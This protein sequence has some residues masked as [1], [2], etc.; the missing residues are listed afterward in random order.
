MG[1]VVN[2]R[3][4]GAVIFAGFDSTPADLLMFAVPEDS[5]AVPDVFRWPAV[6]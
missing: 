6:S 4:R 1:L 2:Y 5:G 3:R